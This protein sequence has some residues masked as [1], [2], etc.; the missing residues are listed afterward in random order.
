[1]NSVPGLSFW[2]AFKP[3]EIISTSGNLM[4]L[5][6]M[7]DIFIGFDLS[8]HKRFHRRVQTM[9]NSTKVSW[10]K[11]FVDKMSQAAATYSSTIC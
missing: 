1:M 9:G 7:F 6:L 5:M 8:L 4:K 11:D 3:L 10:Y 2:Q